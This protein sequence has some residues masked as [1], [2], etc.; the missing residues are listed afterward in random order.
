MIYTCWGCGWRIKERMR[1]VDPKDIGKHVLFQHHPFHDKYCIDLFINNNYK[2]TQTQDLD[3]AE[4]KAARKLRR[5][6]G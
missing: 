5:T 3:E 2:R 1:C 6:S 4:W